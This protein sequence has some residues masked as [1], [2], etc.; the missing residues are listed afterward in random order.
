M[1]ILNILLTQADMMM[2][3]MMILTCM[4]SVTE[5][6]LASVRSHRDSL[7]LMFFFC[8]CM[9]RHYV[10]LKISGLELFD[11][12]TN[13]PLFGFITFSCGDVSPR[14]LADEDGR[15]LV[16]VLG[17]IVCLLFKDCI[18]SSNKNNTNVRQTLFAVCWNV[19]GCF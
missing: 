16:S 11:I 3:M 4:F 12:R 18:N 19:R 15:T 1:G 6:K 13:L 5:G 14:L 9:L 7:Q 10:E 2:M 8:C 17:N